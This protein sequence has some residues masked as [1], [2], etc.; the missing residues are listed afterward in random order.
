MAEIIN[1]HNYAMIFISFIV[2]GVIYMLGSICV[3]FA[4]SKRIISHKF[5]IHGTL[6]E[7][8]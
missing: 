2:V 6:I 4:K 5:L 8:I 3:E 7:T 1:F